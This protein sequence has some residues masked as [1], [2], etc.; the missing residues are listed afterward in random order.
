[1][2]RVNSLSEFIASNPASINQKFQTAPNRM[3]SF[4]D[5]AV[6][7]DQTNVVVWLMAKGAQETPLS[8]PQLLCQAAMN[9][10]MTLCEMLTDKGWDPW[11]SSEDPF[12]LQCPLYQ[13]VS[14]GNLGLLEM[15]STKKINFKQTDPDTGNNL[16]HVWMYAM[17]HQPSQAKSLDVAKWL[18]KKGV[19]AVAVNQAGQTPSDLCLYDT[20]RDRFNHVWQ[21]W[22][23]A[24]SKKSLAQSIKSPQAA[25]ARTKKRM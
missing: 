23:S 4:L 20:L 2:G 9:G 6:R 5:V 14:S 24:K 25:R 21:E 16:L 8:S 12:A 11:M 18:M 10:N 19:S 3:E 13:C 1:M 17:S 22:S 15:W 7:S